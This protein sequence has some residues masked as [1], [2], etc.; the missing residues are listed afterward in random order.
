MV[1]KAGRNCF[2]RVYIRMIKLRINAKRNLHT[3]LVKFFIP[4]EP[5]A[6]LAP[7]GHNQG[8]LIA[9]MVEPQLVHIIEDG[10]GQNLL[11]CR[12]ACHDSC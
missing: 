10:W 8:A 3:G 11:D 5:L 2:L 6:H 9:E 12:V 1:S 7:R 4:G